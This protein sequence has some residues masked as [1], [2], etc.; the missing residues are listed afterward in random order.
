MKIIFQSTVQDFIDSQR[1]HAW[2]RYSPAKARL[3]RMLSP[4]FGSLLVVIGLV[5]YKIGLSIGL[6]IFEI[7]CGLYV[8]L[9]TSVVAPLLYRRQ[10][11]RRHCG[12]LHENVITFS[13]E[14][15]DC[16]SP[17]H[18]QG[19]LEWPAIRG[20]IES[21]TTILLYLAPAH[22]LPIPK[23]VVSESEVQEILTM[24]RSK[25]IPFSCPRPA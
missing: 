21:D 15:I 2:R 20:V 25:G 8:A 19:T 7:V 13:D 17:G 10:Y 5:G 18:S 16:Q 23:R 14:S 11:R 3:Q 24:V 12:Q 22:F 1:T 9:G 4:V 6:V